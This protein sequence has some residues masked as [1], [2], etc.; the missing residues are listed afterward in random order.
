MNARLKNYGKIMFFVLLMGMITATLLTV[1]DLLT[2]GLIAQN[3]LSLRQ[4]TILRSQGVTEFTNEN[5]SQVFEEE[6]ELIQ[7]TV[8]YKDFTESN[9]LVIVAYR[10]KVTLSVTIEFNKNFGA[11]VWGPIIGYL[12]LDQ[13]LVTIESVAIISQKETP[14]LGAKVKEAKFLD[15]LIGKIM[16]PAL[17]IDKTQ[18]TAALD[19]Y[20]VSIVGATRTSKQFEALLNETYR[21][22]ILPSGDARWD[23]P[24]GD[25]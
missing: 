22:H 14:G 2:R 7:G 8:V 10:N 12:T 1:S 9:P 21:V 5:L 17:R 4:S 15:E 19:N 3:Q 13:D 11:G 18:D 6:V 20:V 23:S 25:N 24:L 16:V